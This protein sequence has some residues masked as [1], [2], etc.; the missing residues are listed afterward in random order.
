LRRRQG[1]P[2]RDT[3]SAAAYVFG[4]V[5]AGLA[6]VYCGAPR[7]GYWLG[8]AGSLAALGLAI[9]AACIAF[10]GLARTVKRVSGCERASGVPQATA[11][12]LP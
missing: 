2:L 12:P 11:S 3:A 5:T 8:A 1:V 10:P 9:L 4:F 6:L 7:W